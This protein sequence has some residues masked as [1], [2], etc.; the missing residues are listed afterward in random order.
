MLLWFGL[1]NWVMSQK[2]VEPKKD[3]PINQ[4][5]QILDCYQSLKKQ[6][7]GK[8]ELY[9]KIGEKLPTVPRPTIRRAVNQHLGYKPKPKTQEKETS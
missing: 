9:D 4:T 8:S 2:L 7:L 1:A 5:R 3:K 6:N